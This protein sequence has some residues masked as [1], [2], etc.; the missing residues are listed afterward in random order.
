MGK[1][2]LVWR[3]ATKDLRHRPAEAV[4]LLLAIAT[5]ATA[6]T[7]GM[8][9][10]GATN[11]P[12]AAT[13]AATNGPD[14]VVTEVPGGPGNPG[15]VNAAVL[16]RLDH[17]SGV[18]AHSGPFPVTWA[19]LRARGLT[20]GAEIEGR[21]SAPSAVDQPKLTSGSWV[22]PGGVVVEGGFARALGLGI[23][24]RVTLGR[25]SFRV[26]GIAVTAAIPNYSGVCFLGCDMPGNLGNYNPGLV[27]LT[28]TGAERVAAL[29]AEPVGYFA[30]LNLSDPAQA[31]DFAN[32]YDANTSPRAPFLLS[33]QSIRNEDSTTISNDQVVLLTGSWLLGLLA[34][35]S[36]VVLVGARM[37]GQTR[38]VGLVKAVGGTPG[39]VATVF[40]FEHVL[41]AL[42]AAGVGLL[43]GWLTAPLLTGPGAGLVG[44][45]GAPPLGASA[46]GLVAAMAL[47][48]AVIATFVP[49]IRAARISTV[50]ALGDAVRTPRRRAWVVT[51]S[52]RLPLPLLLGARLAAR[53]PR[54]LVLSALSVAITASG[55][56]AVLAVRA[57][58]ASPGFLAPND[59]QNLQL[60]Q[61]TS[62][63]SV[64]L[65]VLAVVNAILIA[66]AMALDARHSS[67]LARAL[68]AT[69]RQVGTALSVAQIFPALVGAL[70]GIPGGIGLYD[71]AKHGGS[72]AVPPTSW[73][74][75]MVLGTV[76][77]VAVL[78]AV[79]ARIG[80]R[81]SVAEILQAETA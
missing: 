48:V 35:A 8:A 54:R 12:Y 63:I 67:A 45:P 44:A 62:V 15:P 60:D 10:H 26:T 40:L 53:R 80:A 52:A 30:D 25:V 39:L 19:L 50:S 14:V 57:T 32:A 5:A 18:V 9:L 64:M 75:A 11:N 70:L 77:V 43:A 59:P 28:Q 4:L 74:V 79:P 49:A 31:G 58:D 69:S 21:S 6:L 17:A 47:G 41:L 16:T 55:I 33:W 36:V 22:R 1:L 13:R 20:A 3:L 37:A 71:A 73:L 68:G 23:G 27:W 78:T 81:R 7:L 61:V 46:I 2:L 56:V 38:R 29:S 66:W 42:C 76:V 24:D 34:L 51:F 65:I 72:T